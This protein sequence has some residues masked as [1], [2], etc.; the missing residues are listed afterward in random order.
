MSKCVHGHAIRSSAD[1]HPN[2]TCVQC[3]RIRSRNYAAECRLARKQLRELRA[4]IAS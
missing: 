3:Q 1:R 2:G 4:L